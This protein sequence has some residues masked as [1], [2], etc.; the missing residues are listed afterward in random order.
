[1]ANFIGSPLEDRYNRF[2]N[3]VI[4]PLDKKILTGLTSPRL[5]ISADTM[6]NITTYCENITTMI[7]NLIRQGTEFEDKEAV[8]DY[9]KSTAASAYSDLNSYMGI[10]A[11]R[12]GREVSVVAITTAMEGFL[13]VIDSDAAHPGHGAGAGSGAGL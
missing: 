2:W 9:I 7:T 5:Y 8:L 13:R 10:L 11:K 4:V 3:V 6:K 12:G 1:M